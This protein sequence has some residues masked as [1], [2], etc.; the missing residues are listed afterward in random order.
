MNQEAKDR[1][2][3]IVQDMKNMGLRPMEAISAA[4]VMMSKEMKIVV[5]KKED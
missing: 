4:Q 2:S 5:K 3:Q 1:F